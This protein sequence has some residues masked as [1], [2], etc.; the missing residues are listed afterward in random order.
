[1]D[2]SRSRLTRGSIGFGGCCDVVE[3]VEGMM[4][5][6]GSV[7]V[8]EFAIVVV[9]GLTVVVTAIVVVEDGLTVVVT[10][11]GDVTV[12]EVVLTVVEE[13][14]L[15]VIAVLVDI[16]L[17]VAVDSVTRVDRDVD[18]GDVVPGSGETVVVFLWTSLA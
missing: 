8:V 11:P 9:D 13:L 7:V 15:L 4:D 10:V 3:T 1:M 18:M 16:W 2:M 17:V 14:S 5:V 12:V 6:E